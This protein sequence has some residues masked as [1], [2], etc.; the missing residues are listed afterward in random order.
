MF[1]QYSSNPNNDLEVVP[2]PND[3]VSALA[4]SP[5]ANFLVATSW[6]NGV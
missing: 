3:T 6:D 1:G 4:W 2:P 5:K